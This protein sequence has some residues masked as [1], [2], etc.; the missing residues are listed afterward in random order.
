[1][2]VSLTVLSMLA[3]IDK[4]IVALLVAPIKSDLGLSDTQIGLVVGSAFA[5]AHLSVAL[6]A[7]W[8]AD[9]YS[10]RRLIAAGVA[11]WSVMATLCGTAQSFVQLF[12]A[13]AGVGFGEGLIPPP[14]YSLIRDGVAPAQRGRAFSVYAMAASTGAGLSLLLGALL[15]ATISSLDVSHLPLI[16][17]VEPW[18]VCLIVVGLGGLPFTL[19]PFT[20]R[21]PGRE[22]GTAG[23][24]LTFAATFHHARVHGRAMGA[25]LAF[26]V[27]HAMMT[28]SIAAW[29]PAVLGRN[30]GLTPREIG[31]A[32]G[33]LLVVAPP[34]GLLA[35]GQVMDRAA[36]YGSEGPAVVAIGAAILFGI[37]AVLVP[38]APDLTSF[39]I[40]QTMVVLASTIY[41]PVTSTVVAALVPSLGV[42]KTMAAYLFVQGI[43]G[44]GLSPVVAA[45]IADTFLPGEAHGLSVALS[46]T[47]A[48][49]GSLA[50][51]A[52]LKLRS[53]LRGLGTRGS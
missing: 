35:A 36:R 19:L 5:L 28:A 42:G 11:I 22:R 7:G 1:M 10:R 27:L 4:T 32:L 26:S 31:S 43:F 13:R 41:L 25:L 34:V 53:E 38:L 52:A 45:F 20:F 17:P 24:G 18:Q 39:W 9:R 49:Y 23:H 2:V 30:F 12:A 48:L 33:A 6:P 51:L 40:L 29:A 37:A 16:G 44:G 3:Q 21:D 47:G 15:L 50:L 46:A 8:L 14:S